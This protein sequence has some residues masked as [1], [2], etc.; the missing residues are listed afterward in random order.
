VKTDDPLMTLLQQELMALASEGNLLIFE[1][2]FAHH[3]AKQKNLTSK[4]QDS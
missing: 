1:D 4:S 3:L 2:E